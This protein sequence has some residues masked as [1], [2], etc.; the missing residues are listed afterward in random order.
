MIIAFA[1]VAFV[2]AF[3]ASAKAAQTFGIKTRA[4][5]WNA[6]EAAGSTSKAQQHWMLIHLRDDLSN[7]VALLAIT[8]GLLAAIF[9]SLVLR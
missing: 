4:S 5:E 2:L 6:N 8:N 9:V 3:L 1:V 7:V